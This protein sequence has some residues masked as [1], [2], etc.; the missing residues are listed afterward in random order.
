[1]FKKQ[2]K[3]AV[4]A[5]G[6]SVSI[7]ASETN[8]CSPRNNSGPY[9][10]VELGYPSEKDPIIL[11]YAEDS[12]DPTGTVYGY[13]PSAIVLECLDSHGGWVSGEIPPM[14]IHSSDTL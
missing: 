5:D 10:M 4:C 2:Y 1:M 8:Y 13:V 6:F 9:I 3:K 14:N 12:G 11:P 7:Q